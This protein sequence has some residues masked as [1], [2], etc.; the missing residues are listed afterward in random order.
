MLT[1]DPYP[2]EITWHEVMKLTFPRLIKFTKRSEVANQ[3][4]IVC[5]P[6]Q[7]W[8]HSTNQKHNHM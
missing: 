4:F 2:L 6:L 7:D 8:D 5:F 3:I 1:R